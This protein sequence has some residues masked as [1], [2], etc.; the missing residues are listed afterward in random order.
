MENTSTFVLLLLSPLIAAAQLNRPANYDGAETIEIYSEIVDDTFTVS[1][2]L[3]LA[4]ATNTDKRY[5]IALLVDGDFYFP[6]MA[7]LIRQYEMTGLLQPMILVGIGYGDFQKMDSLRI[8]DF[9]YPAPLESDELSA[10][11][12]GLDFYRFIADELLPHLETGLR[13]DTSQRTLMGHSFGGYF[14]L[15]ALLQQANEGKT[16]FSNIIAAS[17]T[18]WYH[19]FYLHRLPGKLASDTPQKA[20]NI[21]LTAGSL[22]NGEWT[23][24]PIHKLTVSFKN[25]NIPQL[26]LDT[27]IY[28]FLDHMDTGQLSFVKGLQHIYSPQLIQ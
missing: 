19:D 15:Y 1:V 21:V 7:P 5:P 12:G 10:S 25:E 13:I 23:L 22:E 3:P 20:L 16:V 18:L 26:Y 4:Y 11:G 14:A 17:P 8:R 2:Q 6:T 9:L 24:N 28:N 27:F